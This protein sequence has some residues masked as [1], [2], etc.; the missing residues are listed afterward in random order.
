MGRRI[1]T[2]MRLSEVARAVGAA[3]P[4]PDGFVRSVGIDSRRLRRG[5]LFVALPGARH[6][7]HNFVGEARSRGAVAAVVDR[8][9]DADIR[10]LVIQNTMSALGAIARAW[11][12]RFATPLIAVAGSNGKTT[13][14]EMLGSIFRQAAMGTALVTRGNLNNEI[15]VPLTLLRLRDRHRFAVI[16]MGANHSGEI[17]YLADLVRPTMGVI[18]NAGLDHVAGFG[19]P[20]GAARANGEMFAAMDG[21]AIAVLNADDPCFPIWEEL[22]GERRIIAFGLSGKRAEVRGG[23]CSTARGGRLSIQSPWGA[24]DIDLALAG[25]HNG[26][27]ALAAAAAAH[28]LGVPARA[29]MAGLSAVRPVKGRLHSHQGL[30][31]ARLIDDSYNANP[32]SLDAALAVLAQA[33]GE[34]VVVLGDMAELGDDAAI[35]HERAGR[36][37]RLA[38]V[39]RLFAIG[40]LSRHAADAFGLGAQHF[41]DH[42]ALIF[43]LSD[44]LH[45]DVTVLIKGSRRM[46]MEALVDDL[47]SKPSR[48]EEPVSQ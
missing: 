6:D 3:P 14:K 32:S 25:R 41:N 15:G 35:W 5:D 17:A 43:A 19:G 29:I 10:Q 9:V 36:S 8:Q 22:A 16:E 44:I 26:V 34:K 28:A 39:D 27:N 37:A 1:A 45:A 42:E 4:V 13:V 48:K 21:D 20:D 38:G 40:E 7:G 46:R 31:G 23:W 11:R 33:R 18:T 30:H 24:Y 12:T 47:I 2:R